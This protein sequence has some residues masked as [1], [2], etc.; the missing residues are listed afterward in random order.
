MENR[1]TRLLGIK[2][3]LILGPMR[4]ITLGVMAAAVSDNGGLGQIATST[5]TNPELREEIRQTRARTVQPFGINIP[6]HRPNALESLETAIEMK[7][8]I[9][10]TSGGNPEKLTSRAKAEGLIVLHKVS[11]TTMGRKA[12][13]AGVDGVIAMGFEAGGHGGRSQLTTFCLVP[14]LCDALKIPVIAAGGISDFRGFLAAL[15][16]GADGIEVGTRF[17]ATPECPVPGY[18]K[19]ALLRAPDTGTVLAGGEAMP[20]RI[21]NNRAAEV[22]LRQGEVEKELFPVVDYVNG[23][24]NEEN[25]IMPAGQ[26]AG[27]IHGI[28]SIKA[29]MVAFGMR[30]ARGS[31]D[32]YRFFKEGE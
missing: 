24:G 6:I 21:L 22:M 11:T 14:Q 12:Q 29:I 32:L 1:L 23:E 4:W 8:P 5:L 2:I 13:E 25:T 18:Y 17:L 26:G 16:L 30:A 28:E 19:E 27:M 20:L 3:P 10:T 9:I 31:Q 7:V 15:A